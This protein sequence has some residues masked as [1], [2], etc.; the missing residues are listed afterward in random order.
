[1]TV[2][3]IPIL[4]PERRYITRREGLRLQGFPET[5]ELPKSRGRAFAALGN[6]VHVD[7]ARTV[8]VAA[9]STA[10]STYKWSAQS[11]H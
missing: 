11:H 4:G 7:V 9:L 2:T 3:Q 1:M 6:A 5:L 10:P 8:I